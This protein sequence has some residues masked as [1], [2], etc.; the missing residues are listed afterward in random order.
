M[1]MKMYTVSAT[2]SIF[3][4]RVVLNKEQARRRRRHIK[5][6]EGDLYEIV[7]PVQFKVG[8]QI[9]LDES[10]LRK[11]HMVNLAA[12][13]SEPAESVEQTESAEENTQEAA[14]EGEEDEQPADDGAD[15]PLE[16][17]HWKKIKELVEAAGGKWDNKVAGIEFLKSQN[18]AG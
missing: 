7:K 12:V 1:T 5:H 4:G 3:E 11:V 6:I 2:T 14:S 13:G 18:N 8:E 16:K 15:V 9:G 10:T 17:M